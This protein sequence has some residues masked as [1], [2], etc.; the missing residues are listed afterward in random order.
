MLEHGGNLSLAAAQYS[1][2]LADWLDLSTGINPN[3]YPL[4]EIS[5]AIWQRLPIEEDGLIE[6]A[7]AFFGS[8]SELPTA[9]SQAAIQI[10]PR[11]RP[12]GKVAMPSLMYKEHAYAWQC[13]GHQISTFTDLDDDIL[14]SADVV[15]L[16]NPNNPTAN[17][18][19]GADLLHLH[20]QLHKRGSWLVVDEAFMDATPENSI[21]QHTHLEGLFVL[22]SLGK[23]FGLAGARVGFLLASPQW[24]SKAQEILG[25]WSLSGPSRFVATQALGDFTWQQNTRIQLSASSLRLAALLSENGLTPQAGTALFQYV[26]VKEAQLRQQ[27]LA[28]QGIWVRYFPEACALR[29]GLPTEDGWGK[30]EAALKSF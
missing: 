5:P 9:G 24:L 28:K 4:P 10:L 19:S 14:N 23:F 27:Q 15:L 7:C 13:C 26:P 1:I 6:A 16:C 30:L 18:F 11:L 25:P 29:F 12:P 22:R 21:A 17:R 20:S 8:R 3:G 2:P